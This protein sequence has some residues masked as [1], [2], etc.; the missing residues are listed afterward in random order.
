M[1]LCLF[2]VWCRVMSC[3]ARRCSLFLACCSSLVIDRRLSFVVLCSVVLCCCVL[4]LLLAGSGSNSRWTSGARDNHVFFSLSLPPRTPS[5]SHSPVCGSQHA[6]LCTFNSKRHP[7]VLAP[8]P[9]W[10]WCRYTRRLI[11]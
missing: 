11:K 10:R 7:C 5:L 4:L 1:S 3:V 8:R 9:M 6:S 2:V